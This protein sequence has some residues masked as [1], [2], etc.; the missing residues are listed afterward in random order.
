M[1]LCEKVAAHTFFGYH[2]L[3]N[4]ANFVLWACHLAR[5]SLIFHNI[6]SFKF[7]HIATHAHMVQR[8]SI[9]AQ[10]QTLDDTHEQ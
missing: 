10:V 1:P 7:V 4:P 3:L 8:F 2:E 9:L 6:V 5:P